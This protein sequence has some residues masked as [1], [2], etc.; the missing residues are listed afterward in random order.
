MALDKIV[1]GDLKRQIQVLEEQLMA[2][3]CITLGGR[4]M[5]WLIYK[6]FRMSNADSASIE[7]KDLFAVRLH[8]DNL[9][10]FYSD[11]S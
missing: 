8:G 10:K 6:H 11:W 4:C 3:K 7:I 9:D 1:V 5:L 2:Q